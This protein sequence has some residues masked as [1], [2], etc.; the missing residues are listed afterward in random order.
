MLVENDYIATFLADE[1]NH[2]FFFTSFHKDLV[3]RFDEFVTVRESLKILGEML[4]KRSNYKVLMKYISEKQ[5]L[6]TIMTVM[7]HKAATIK[8]EAFHVFKIFAANP[9][10]TAPVEELLCANREALLTYLE[11]FHG[12]TDDDQTRDELN[13]ILTGLKRLKKKEEGAK[14]D[15]VKKDGVKKEDESRSAT[16]ASDAAADK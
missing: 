12:E 8:L 6:K 7:A 11:R 14:A 13:M 16:D 2:E 5:N 9:K 4:L 15:E 3:L 10:K 1:K